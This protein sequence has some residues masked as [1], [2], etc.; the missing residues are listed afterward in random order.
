M[1]Q[2]IYDTPEFFTNY[3]QLTRSVQG[4]DGA[5]EWPRLQSFLPNLTGA[6][7]VDLGCGM[8]WYCRWMRERGATSVRGID[9]SQNMLNRAREMDITR[10]I[11]GITYERTDLD[12]IEA[13]RNLFPE[14]ENAT[15]DVVFSSLAV[16]YLANLPQLVAHVHRVL[17]PGGVFVFSAEHPVFTAPSTPEIVEIPVPKQSGDKPGEESIRRVWPL[18]DYHAE[19]LRVTNWLA[20]GVR[21]YH[22]TVT[23][24]V[25]ILLDSGF[26][27]TGFNEWYPTKDELQV[28][29]HPNAMIRPVFLLMRG[30]KRV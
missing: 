17:K 5:V 15:I 20:D 1:S 29:D 4:L 19:G 22:R 21:K 7:V 10:D 8:G 11:D 28:A 2:N 26:E 9:L 3:S 13:Q 27:L 6:R 24:Y 12:D 30:T 18:D 14:S 23:S 16:H 25:N